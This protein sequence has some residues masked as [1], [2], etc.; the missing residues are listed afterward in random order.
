MIEISRKK[1]VFVALF[2]ILILILSRIYIGNRIENNDFLST[3]FTKRQQ[4]LMDKQQQLQVM[5]D[6]FN[7][8]LQNEIKKQENLSNQLADLTEN[9]NVPNSNPPPQP[10]PTP[11]PPPV[12]RAS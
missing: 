9:Q 6:E 8:T 5:I 4:E 3:N 1:I 12:T 7:L 2:I 10:D 11:S